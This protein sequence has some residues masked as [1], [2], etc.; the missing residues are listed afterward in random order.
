MVAYYSEE[1]V[2]LE[3]EGSKCTFDKENG[4]KANIRNQLQ[5]DVGCSH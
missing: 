3:K 4:D 1:I 5:R 2:S